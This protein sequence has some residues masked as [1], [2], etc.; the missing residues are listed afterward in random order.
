[1]TF[2]GSRCPSG[3]GTKQ[4]LVIRSRHDTDTKRASNIE[5]KDP[6]DGRVERAGQDSTRVSDFASDQR[7]VIGAD[8]T[9]TA[10]QRKLV[11][12]NAETYANVAQ[13]MLSKMP[14]TISLP[15]V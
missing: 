5:S 2:G 12:D 8:D 14:R 11:E 9:T 3:N 1:M 13:Q 7:D 4:T 15:L 10:H 6:V